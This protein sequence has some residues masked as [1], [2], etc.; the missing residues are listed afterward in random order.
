MMRGSRHIAGSWMC[1]V[2]RFYVCFVV[3]IVSGCRKEENERH[4]AWL[5]IALLV[6]RTLILYAFDCFS[7]VFVCG[8]SLFSFRSM[9]EPFTIMLDPFTIKTL[10]PCHSRARP[11]SRRAQQRHRRHIFYMMYLLMHLR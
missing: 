7:L 9:V 8:I 5:L 11:R 4:F 2:F 6:C 3:F 1:Y 10:V